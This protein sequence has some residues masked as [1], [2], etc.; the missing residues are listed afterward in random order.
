[1]TVAT[2]A[3]QEPDEFGEVRL[4][5]TGAVIAR[6]DDVSI[7]SVE[8]T[9]S[10]EEFERLVEIIRGRGIGR[11]LLVLTGIHSIVVAQ[12]KPDE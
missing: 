8:R 12:Q 11:Q 7:L 6:P 5:V 1:M 3:T 10:D 4:N 9:L 2:D